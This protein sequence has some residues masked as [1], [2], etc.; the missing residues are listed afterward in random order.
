M[1]LNI[2]YGKISVLG[3]IKP[4]YDLPLTGKYLIVTL[5]TLNKA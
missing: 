5:T 4:Y 3:K 1:L 2:L